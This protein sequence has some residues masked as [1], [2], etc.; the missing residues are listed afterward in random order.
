M[1]P[2][3]LILPH[4]GG[5]MSGVCSHGSPGVKLARYAS[6]FGSLLQILACDHRKLVWRYQAEQ[7]GD[8]R[9]GKLNKLNDLVRWW[10]LIWR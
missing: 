8:E 4:L 3:C 10:C 5:L 9:R 2:E 7:D 6:L 1:K